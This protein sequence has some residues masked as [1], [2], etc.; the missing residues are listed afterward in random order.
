VDNGKVSFSNPVHTLFTSIYPAYLLP[1]FDPLSNLCLRSFCPLNALCLH[2]ICP[3]LAACWQPMPSWPLAFDHHYV[4]H[5]FTLWRAVFMP[6]AHQPSPLPRCG[7]PCMV[8]MTVSMVASP[9]YTLAK[10]CLFTIFWPLLPL[11]H[12]LHLLSPYSLTCYVLSVLRAH[13]CVHL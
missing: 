4:D 5:Q 3:L 10:S 7:N 2:S 13:M 9:R 11:L 1:F 6:C 8:S 12:L